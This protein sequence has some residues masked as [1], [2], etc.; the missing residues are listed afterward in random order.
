[1]SIIN[2]PKTLPSRIEQD[3]FEDF[4]IELMF[5]SFIIQHPANENRRDDD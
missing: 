1:M 2:F 4:V 5:S 3:G